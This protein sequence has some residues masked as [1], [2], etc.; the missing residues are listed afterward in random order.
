MTFLLSCAIQVSVILLIALAV[1]PLFRRKSAA[2]RHCVLS[3]ALV[4]ALLIP[5]F[6]LLMPLWNVSALVSQHPAVAPLRQQISA[7]T[8]PSTRLLPERAGTEVRTGASR[9]TSER[10]ELFRL[11]PRIMWSVWSTGAFV[12]VFALV[13]GLVR[14]ARV[15]SASVPVPS[16]QW[17][18]LAALISRE[19]GLKRLVRL[20]QSRNSS[21]LV[22][23]GV[24]RPEVIVPAG[25]GEWPEDRVRLVLRHELAHIQRGDWLVQMI[26]QTL[27]I[28]YWFN[29]LLWIVCR[30]LRLESECACDDAVLSNDIEGHEY[31]GHLLDV[32]RALNRPDRAWSAA[33]TMARPSTIERRF[34][35]MLN[36]A[37]NRYPVTRFALF[38]TVVVGLCITLSL[39]AASTAVPLLPVPAPIK[40][41]AITPTAPPAT[42]SAT[43]AQIAAHS[44]AELSCQTCHV[45]PSAQA[46]QVGALPGNLR[47]LTDDELYRLIRQAS[48]V[49]PLLGNLP[50]ATNRVRQ[51]ASALDRALVEVAGDGDINDIEELL[52]A[53]ANV[54]G[55][56]FGDG[57][58]L[59][60]AAGDGHV[61]ATRYLLDRGA[62][63]NL[64]VE[65]D[66]N[67]LIAAA[68]EGHI[69][70]VRLL[71][72]R[73][74]DPNAAV[75]GDGNALIAAASE[76]HVD[77][78]A[79]LLDRGANIDQVVAGDE[80]ALIQASGEGHLNVVQL[81]VNRRADVNARV[82]VEPEGPW[83][84][85]GEWRS[86]LSEALREGHQEVVRFLLSVGARE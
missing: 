84:P 49:A 80:N 24:V 59:I 43:P 10:S 14:L 55:V 26:A 4:F 27:R 61:Q 39:S 30:R 48:Q 21:I 86:P 5:V 83:R 15:A 2:F 7:M 25:S 46:A 1:L 47:R 79:L 12:G 11:L 6:D 72:D 52:R 67:P 19:Y 13:T 74:A 53:G 16:R 45:I 58:P 32:A 20:L 71:L 60:A 41:P 75:A 35:A 28:L 18:R 64:A 62:D 85:N 82:W 57:S 68:G 63:P 78:V 34:S 17:V 31:A 66:G 22:T 3:T 8:S 37:L 73:G 76:G 50:L 40:P 44:K 70:V 65:G 51:R 77:V 9:A 38:A 69:E 54:N 42:A 23:W 56:V 81:L 29:P 33:L 36:P